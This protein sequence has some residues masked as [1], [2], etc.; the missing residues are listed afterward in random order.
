M[1]TLTQQ[2]DRRSCKTA[3][4]GTAD[5]P[6]SSSSVPPPRLYRH[7]SLVLPSLILV[8]SPRYGTSAYFLN[9]YDHPR[10]V[11]FCLAAWAGYG[12]L[13]AI[14]VGRLHSQSLSFSLSSSAFLLLS[15]QY[16]LR[17]R[18]FARLSPIQRD[19]ARS[20]EKVENF[21]MIWRA[22]KSNVGY[23]S[24]RSRRDT[25]EKARFYQR[26]HRKA[27]K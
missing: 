3:L 14:S 5:P 27:I 12:D 17:I 6:R 20:W 22:L 1:R 13:G 24:R 16:I 11:L 21:T 9:T 25:P 19:T 18:T 23:R 2:L 26:L 7:G 15:L 4:R 10:V 8:V